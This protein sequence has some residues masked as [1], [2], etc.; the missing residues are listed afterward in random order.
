MFMT[1]LH[2]VEEIVY[3]KRI[4]VDFHRR[5]GFCV[6]VTGVRH[7]PEDGRYFRVRWKTVCT[8]ARK[9]SPPQEVRVSSQILQVSQS[10]SFCGPALLT[11]D[12]KQDVA[13]NVLIAIAIKDKQEALSFVMSCHALVDPN[14]NTGASMTWYVSS[15]SF[16]S[17]PEVVKE[18]GAID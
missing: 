1:E 11:G 8:E 2:T 12:M 5:I 16:D 13:Q 14:N 3:S 17:M 4:I 6:Y 15:E 7:D 10:K 9:I 18:H